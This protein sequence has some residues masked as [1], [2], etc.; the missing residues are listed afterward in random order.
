MVRKWLL[1]IRE[2]KNM[3]HE[4]VASLAEISRQYYSMIE[5]GER[6]PSVAVAKRIADVLGFNW[7]IFFENKG[8]KTLLKQRVSSA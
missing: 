8:N 6:N 1:D 3:T 4:G 5:N 7:I 2:S